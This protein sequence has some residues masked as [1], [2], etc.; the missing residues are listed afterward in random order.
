MITYRKYDFLKKLDCV[1]DE[2]KQQ[3][4]EFEQTKKLKSTP[5]AIEYFRKL[6][7]PEPTAAEFKI[8]YDVL[9][10][11]FLEKYQQIEGVMFN[12]ERIDDIRPVLLYFCKDERFFEC[13]NLSNLSKPSFDKGLLIIGSYGNGKT[14]SM[15]VLTALFK[16]TP[17]SFKSYTANKIVSTFEGLSKAEDR[18]AY[19][20]KTKIGDCYFDDVKAE[21]DAS[22]YGKFNLMREILDARSNH[23]GKTY[24]T[25]N[26]KE[27]DSTQSL[28]IAL[29][30]FSERY[31]ERVDDRLYKEVN[32]IEF[33]GTSLRI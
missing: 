26:Y 13:K 29:Q 1:S 10:H 20:E 15:K 24:I 11:K 28:K 2:E 3:M 16:N 7:K 22:N 8:D 23:N 18:H 21:K 27:R 30:E 32:I 5:E 4:L 12:P 25:A 17:L 19:I 14:S 33:H 31:G 6:R 9:L